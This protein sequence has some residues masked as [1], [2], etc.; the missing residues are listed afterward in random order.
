[1]NKAVEVSKTP[2]FV[3]SRPYSKASYQSVIWQFGHTI[4]LYA[5][6]IWLMFE[7]LAIH[8][9]FTL[10]L[11]LVANAAYTRLFMIGHDCGHG[12]YLPKKYRENRE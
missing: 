4:V 10:A 11:A 5:L 12:S 9:A 6:V 7:S 2:A 3:A 1:M 8:Y